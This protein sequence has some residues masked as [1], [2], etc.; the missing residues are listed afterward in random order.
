MQKRHHLMQ[1][2]QKRQCGFDCLYKLFFDHLS[3]SS[4]RTGSVLYRDWI[5]SLPLT[6]SRGTLFGSQKT[7]FE[8]QAHIHISP[9]S[10]SI[11]PSHQTGPDRKQTLIESIFLF[12]SH[13]A[14]RVSQSVGSSIT[15]PHIY[16]REM[17]WIRTSLY[18]LFQKRFRQRWWIAG[19]VLKNIKDGKTYRNWTV[20][21]LMRSAELP[22]DV[23]GGVGSSWVKT[24]PSGATSFELDCS[25]EPIEWIH[26]LPYA[27]VD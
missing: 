12:H 24:L 11:R 4:D 16:A 14:P 1:K 2:M 7:L 26:G 20:V 17:W 22:I 15:M 21:E 9:C 13:L 8:S 3:V 25:G 19:E 27:V 23:G 6:M 10:E 18:L 5:G